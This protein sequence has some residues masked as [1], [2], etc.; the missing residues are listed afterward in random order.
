[1]EVGAASLTL[2]AWA[3]NPHIYPSSLKRHKYFLSVTA[4]SPW[5]HWNLHLNKSSK[6]KKKKKPKSSKFLT[7]HQISNHQ[8][9]FTLHEIC[10]Q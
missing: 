9:Q 2:P 6:G 5:I 8:I 4:Q 1:M 3:P 7:G 10:S